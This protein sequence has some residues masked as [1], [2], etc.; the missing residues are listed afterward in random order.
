MRLNFPITRFVSILKWNR[1]FIECSTQLTGT[2]NTARPKWNNTN[3]ITFVQVWAQ[4]TKQIT[5]FR[6][7]Y[8]HL[9]SLSNLR[10]FLI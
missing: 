3:A 9:N 7:F 5:S 10:I 8:T 1:T 4:L 2:L 6:V